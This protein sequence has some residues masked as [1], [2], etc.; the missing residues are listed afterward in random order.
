MIWNR[1]KPADP[2]RLI[3]WTVYTKQEVDGGRYCIKSESVHAVGDHYSGT[4]RVYDFRTGKTTVALVSA[5]DVTRIL[6]PDA[7]VPE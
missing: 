4:P 1:R 3:T 2:P 7:V 6:S 5:V